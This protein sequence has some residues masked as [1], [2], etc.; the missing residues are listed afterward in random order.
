[1]GKGTYRAIGSGKGG[2]FMKLALIS[3]VILMILVIVLC[4]AIRF[5]RQEI[6]DLQNTMQT[7]IDANNNL[8]EEIK[9]LNS[10]D[11]IKADNRRE[12]NEKINALYDGDSVDNAIDELCNKNKK[13]K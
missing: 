1:M 7:V 10:I 11:K 3:I 9:K 13:R 5:L 2:L 12:S 8:H 6:D 4:V